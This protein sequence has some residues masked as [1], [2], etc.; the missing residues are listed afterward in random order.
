MMKCEKCK[1]ELWAEVWE[2]TFC[3]L[4][5]ANR[6]VDPPEDTKQAPQTEHKSKEKRDGKVQEL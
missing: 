4:C 1:G 5:G 3:P 6:K 2:A